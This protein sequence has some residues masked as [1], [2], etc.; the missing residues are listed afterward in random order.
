MIEEAIN[1]FQPR[2]NMGKLKLIPKEELITTGPVDH[3]D[4]NYKSAIKYIQLKRFML[5]LK[6][7]GETEYKKLLEI[8]YG[9]G[10]FLP[11]LSN[12][13]NE[14]FGIDIHTKNKQV[15]EILER[16]NIKV[17][18]FSGSATNMPFEDKSFD[19]I[20]SIS[21][22]EFIDKIEEACLEIKRVLKKNGNL[23]II[24]PGFS[25][26][27][28]TG[29]KILTGESAKKDYEDRRKYLIPKLSKYFQIKDKITFPKYSVP[30]LFLYHGLKFTV[31]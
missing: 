15:E 31:L 26:L 10:I 5:C 28:D 7:L 3:A 8:G 11:T 6:L 27:I 9:S 30:S 25:T 2:G 24:T 29:L 21:S 4:W 1:L 22:I 19:C 18:L 12:F 13:T 20:V 16:K 14:L 17:N 23:I